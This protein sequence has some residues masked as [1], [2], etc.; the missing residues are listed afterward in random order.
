MKILVTGS[1]GFIGRHLIQNL[2]EHEI[3][4]FD[5]ATYRPAD[6]FEVVDFSKIDFIYHLGA[7]TNTLEKNVEALYE[8]NVRF[9]IN[10]FEEAISHRIPVVYTSSASVY[11]NTMKEEKY[12]YN[13]LN[14]YATTKMITEMWISENIK[15]FQ[16]ISVPRLF[17]VYGNDE[18][19]TDQTMS[20]VSKFRHQAINEGLIKVFDGS[21]NM[22]RDFISIKDV[23]S[24]LKNMSKFG[25]YGFHDV[26]TSYPISFLEV[27]KL[28]SN[29]Y[30][31]GIKFI[32]MPEEM[33]SSYQYYTKARGCYG[34]S[35]AHWLESQ[36]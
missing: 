24:V 4:E 21:E 5:T 31:V 3:I 2:S 33:R 35:V 8:H 12:I 15:R 23:I 34:I 7:I 10:L 32:P 17:N 9:S 11:G 29:K 25:L 20:P 18:L 28:I 22:I 1:K 30:Y 14:Y 6:I 26:G 27:A 13:P 16:F 36:S 19:K